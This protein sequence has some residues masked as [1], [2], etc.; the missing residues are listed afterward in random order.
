MT[1]EE[2]DVLAGEYVLGT[3]AADERDFVATLRLRDRTLN[4]A[5]EDWERRL[6][7]LGE[8]IRPVNPN[9]SILSQVQT[10]IAVREAENAKKLQASI[11]ALEGLVRRWRSVAIVTTA[12]AAT[13][14]VA[15]GI[16][17]NLL[18]PTPS[19]YVAVFQKGDAS[20]AFLLTIDLNTRILS[21]QAVAAPVEPGKTY[22]L[23]IAADPTGGGPQSLGVIEDH[24]KATHRIPTSYDASVVQR[25]TFGVS[26]EPVGGSPTGKPTGPVFHAKLIPTPK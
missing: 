22:Q 16:N 17:A 26:L 23:W 4:Q 5:I 14:L 13:I 2:I 11:V 7:P 1:Q 15:V 12:L 6:A 10:R 21:I 18:L 25:A 24:G 20:P 19:N 3:L 9:Q 8:T